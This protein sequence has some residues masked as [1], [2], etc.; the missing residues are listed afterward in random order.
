MLTRYAC[1][2][3]AQ[4]GDPSKGPH[5]LAQTY[6]AIQTASGTR[7]AAGRDGAVAG[8]EEA[9]GFEKELSGI[10]SSGWAMRRALAGSGARATMP[11]LAV[12]PRSR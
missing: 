5:R 4:N 6:F 8:P 12:T 1:Y 11:S 2:L 3:I 7:A 10:I 9:D